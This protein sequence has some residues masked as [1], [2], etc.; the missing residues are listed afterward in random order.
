[1][2][3]EYVGEQECAKGRNVCEHLSKSSACAGSSFV[4]S[5]GQVWIVWQ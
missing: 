2:G 3:G 5:D 1:M 4:R